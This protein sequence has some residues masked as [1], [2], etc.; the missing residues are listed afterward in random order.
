LETG[1]YRENGIL[2]WDSNEEIVDPLDLVK[3]GIDPTVGQVAAFNHG[4]APKG[5]MVAVRPVVHPAV[6]E[7]ERILSERL[8]KT[9]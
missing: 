2:K 7:A 3:V 1:T 5:M 4:R 9:A 6:A 8:W